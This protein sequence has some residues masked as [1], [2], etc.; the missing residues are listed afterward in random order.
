MNAVVSRPPHVSQPTVSSLPRPRR[1]RSLLQGKDPSGVGQHVGVGR[2]H[3][4]IAHRLG[5]DAIA[6]GLVQRRAHVAVAIPGRS[7]SLEPHAMEHPVSEE[8]MAR[9]PALRVRTVPH[10]ETLQVRRHLTRDRQVEHRDLVEHRRVV[11]TQPERCR[12]LLEGRHR[13]RVSIWIFPFTSWRIRTASTAAVTASDRTRCEHALAT[14]AEAFQSGEG[15]T[16]ALAEPPRARAGRSQQPHPPPVP[17]G[18]PG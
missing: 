7:A 3:R 9:R 16:V 5:R 17:A 18:V 8:P 14:I 11:A 1:E 10:V 6:V 13:L 4:E 2:A 15:S 12:C